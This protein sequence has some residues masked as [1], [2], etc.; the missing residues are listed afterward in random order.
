MKVKTSDSD[1]WQSYRRARLILLIMFLSW[2]PI[3]RVVNEFY[4]RFHLPL[5]V[6]IG[7]GI[8]W[9]VGTGVQ[10]LRIASWPCPY[11]GKS[12]RGL[13]PFLPSRCRNCQHTR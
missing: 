7:T 5:L 3:M 4:T 6:P 12:F 9:I 13:L 2:I 1:P 11:C 10:G 8:I